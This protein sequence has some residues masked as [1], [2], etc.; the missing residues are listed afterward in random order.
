VLPFPFHFLNANQAMNVKPKS[1]GWAEFYDHLIDLTR[2]SFSWKNIVRRARATGLGFP[3][4]VNV[5]RAVSSDGLGRIR[6]YETVRRL[7][8]TDRSM[9]RFFAG[10][11]REL[12]S[13]YVER[14]RQDLGPLWELLPPGALYHDPNAY[15]RKTNDPAAL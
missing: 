5:L 10:E 8:D 3:T 2:Y 4:W 12:P 7:L 9:Q 15:L 11:T 1:Y 14:I 13:F 6:Y